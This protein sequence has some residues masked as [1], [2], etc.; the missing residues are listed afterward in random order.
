MFPLISSRYLLD[1][2]P[3]VGH[4]AQILSIILWTGGL[5]AMKPASTF[6]PPLLRPAG[7]EL[8]GAR[9]VANTL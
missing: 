5:V 4:V 7:A 2:N 9:N 1:K 3:L 8:S 6:A